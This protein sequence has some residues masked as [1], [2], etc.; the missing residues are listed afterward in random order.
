[1]L[2]SLDGAAWSDFAPPA[3]LAKGKHPPSTKPIILKGFSSKD[4]FAWEDLDQFREKGLRLSRHA[5]P[6]IHGQSLWDVGQGDPIWTNASGFFQGEWIRRPG[7]VSRRHDSYNLTEGLPPINWIAD[8]GDWARNLTGNNGRMLLRIDANKTVTEYNQFS[9]D[10]AP[11]S[12]GNIRNVKGTVT[13]E[14]TEGSGLTWEMRLH[15]V[16]WPRQGVIMMTTTSEK[17]EGIFGLPYLTP[18]PDY[19]QS[20][21]M[22]LNGTLNHIITNR[23]KNAHLNQ[24]M[25]WSSNI[26]NTGYTSSPSPQ[27][28]YVMYAQL[29]PPDRQSLKMG[30]VG[31][32]KDNMRDVIHAIESELTFPKGSPTPKMPQLQMSTVFYSPD[33]AF[34]MESKG[35]PDFTSGEA[36]HLAGTNTEAHARQ[37]KT[38]LILYAL[39][40][41]GQLYLLR[42]QMKEASSP[43]MMGRVSFGALGMMAAVDAMTFSA[44]SI[45]V[46]SA[47]ASL[48]PSLALMFASFLSMTIGGGFLAKIYEVQ[49][50][51][52]RTRQGENADLSNGASST[53]NDPQSQNQM[54]TYS[55]LPAPITAGRGVNAPPTPIIVPSDQDIDAEIAD[56]AS[57]VPG[58]TSGARPPSVPLAFQTIISRTALTSFCICFVA[59]SSSSWYA[60]VRSLFLNMCALIYMS[61]WLPQI[62]RNAM[63][64][65]RRA[66]A[67]RFVVGQSVLRLLPIAY[68][69]I[70]PDNFLY[71]RVERRAFAVL[72]IWVWLQILVLVAQDV[73]GPRFCIPARWT[74]D[75]WDYH[76]ILR[77]N[78]LEAGGLPIGLVAED[79]LG[80][81]RIGSSEDRKKSSV[82]H[83]IDCSVCM[84]VLEVPVVRAGD[85][86][87]SVA[88]VFIRRMY[89]VTPCRHIFHTACLENWMK[90]RLKC[91]ICR[92]DLPPV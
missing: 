64:N 70:K 78:S 3:W 85:D 33:C 5:V 2:N 90:F 12:G 52:S 82:I 60:S 15:G 9:A 76:P 6:P 8:K 30:L 59:I 79:D 87:T 14:D 74:P 83:V 21:R 69:W 35:P 24:Q 55:L 11:L 73:L 41:F 28:E 49:I 91:P 88:G 75:V 71:A 10:H 16:H 46:S 53:V 77:E 72:C 7:S 92:E 32:A 65:C 81:G 89:M 45:W 51:E 62:Y 23:E 80:T 50:P 1:M 86:D 44:S 34:F 36:N 4:G 26:D 38:W 17:F 67:W 13:V 54:G 48:L 18:G 22:F 47:G 39:V 27:C 42:E 63:R 31:D 66:L 56:G 58:A 40:V 84:E 68:F 20:S 19:F 29:S 57:A 61:F 43:S 25:P 37:I